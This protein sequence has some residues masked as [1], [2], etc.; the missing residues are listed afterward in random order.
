[1]NSVV[2]MTYGVVPITADNV[3]AGTA[4][5]ETQLVVKMASAFTS[6]AANGSAS[7]P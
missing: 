2:K 4:G 1:M 6:V 7:M 3:P 5:E